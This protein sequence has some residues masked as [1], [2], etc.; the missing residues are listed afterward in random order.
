[1]NQNKTKMARLF[2]NSGQDVTLRDLVR[3]NLID[4]NLTFDINL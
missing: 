4:K 2:A 3:L 1:M